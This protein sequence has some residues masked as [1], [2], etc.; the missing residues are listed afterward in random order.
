MT[1]RLVIPL[2]RRF[3]CCFQTSFSCFEFHAPG[4]PDDSSTLVDDTRDTGPVSFHNVITAVYH[5]L[6]AL[7]DEV[8][9]TSQIYSKPDDCPYSGIHT[10]S[11]S[12]TCENTDTFSFVRSLLM[13]F[14][15]HFQWGY[16]HWI[17]HV[18]CRS[19]SSNNSL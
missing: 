1:A 7:L 12:P 19:E 3:F 14:K 5:S 8:H 6:V 10:R 17:C 2:S 11:I 18:S 4:R 9:L 13:L 16:W 15:F